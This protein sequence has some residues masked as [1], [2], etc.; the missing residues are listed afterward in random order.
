[1][2]WLGFYTT[3]VMETPENTINLCG[4]SEIGVRLFIGYGHKLLFNSNQRKRFRK[5]MKK[6]TTKKR[7]ANQL[8]YKGVRRLAVRSD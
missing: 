3:I 2:V 1:M 8:P 5:E 4:V 6:T 7:L